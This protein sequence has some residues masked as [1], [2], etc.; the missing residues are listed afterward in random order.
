MS[1]SLTKVYIHFVWTTKNRNRSLV[2]EARKLV[3][4]HIRSYASEKGICI[5]DVSVEPEHVHALVRLASDQPIE[6]IVKLLKGESS[7]WINQNEVLPGKF[8]WQT[9]YAAFSVDYRGLGQVKQY[10]RNQEEHHKR[11]TYAEEIESTLRE[12]G[13]AQ[14]EIA[15]M[16]KV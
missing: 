8:A 11:R 9:G 3:N 2:N 4:D 1:H 5:E 15:E 13:Y 7:Y 12:A 14:S 16:L 10:I 6:E